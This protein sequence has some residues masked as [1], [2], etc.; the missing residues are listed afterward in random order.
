MRLGVIFS[1]SLGAKFYHFWFLVLAHRFLVIRTF[2]DRWLRSILSLMYHI[3]ARAVT[4]HWTPASQ[5]SYI[6]IWSSVF[7]TKT[8]LNVWI[9]N[10]RWER[11]IVSCALSKHLREECRQN[12][13]H[14]LH[15]I[16]NVESGYLFLNIYSEN[17]M[18]EWIFYLVLKLNIYNISLLAKC[19]VGD[20]L[21]MEV[22]AAGLLFQ[23]FLSHQPTEMKIFRSSSTIIF[24]KIWLNPPD[25]SS[26]SRLHYFKCLQIKSLVE[27]LAYFTNS[28]QKK[29]GA[30]GC[31]SPSSCLIF[32]HISGIWGGEL[33]L[34]IS[35]SGKQ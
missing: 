22:G 30:G 24:V 13:F 15:Q 7:I 29:Q 8:P 34:D 4:M 21:G 20:T 12:Y 9:W 1:R 27:Y 17:L 28:E 33:F 3:G 16:L 35:A 6:K 23:H 18:E 25:I 32:T 10:V 5:R 2:S 31:L 26:P 11:K 19:H 14:D